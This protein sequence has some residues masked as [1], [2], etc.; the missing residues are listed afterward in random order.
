MSRALISI[1]DDFLRRCVDVVP[2]LKFA[3]TPEYYQPDYDSDEETIDTGHRRYEAMLRYS[4]AAVRSFCC[5]LPQ[6]LSL[7]HSFLAYWHYS[8]VCVI[9]PLRMP[10]AN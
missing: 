9:G 1:V 10:L 4:Q 2:D 6:S 8:F 5:C 3:I 7:A